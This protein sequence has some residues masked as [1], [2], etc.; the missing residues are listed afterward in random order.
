MNT[1]KSEPNGKDAEYEAIVRSQHRTLLRKLQAEVFNKQKEEI[2]SNAIEHTMPICD[3]LNEQNLIEMECEPWKALKNVL[4]ISG[5]RS[6]VSIGGLH[7]G[8]TYRFSVRACVKDL[9]DGCGPEKV[10]LA[11]TLSNQLTFY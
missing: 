6:S 8:K 3:H 9:I 4:E 2:E 1:T 5:I 10:V 7:P 11:A